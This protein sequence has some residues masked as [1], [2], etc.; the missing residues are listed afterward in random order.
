MA[1]RSTSTR[2]STAPPPAPP[3]KHRPGRA[4]RGC[5]ATLDRAT[6]DVYEGRGLEWAARRRPVRRADARA[7]ATAVTEGQL[8]IDVGCGAGRY[9]GDLGRPVIGVDAARRML[10][11]CRRVVP[12]AL[13]VQ[14][15]IEALPFGA[16]S[17][18]G[19]WANMS[20]LHV[21]R[22][23]LPLALADLH[24]CLLPGAPV[25]VQVLHG[26]YEGN[27]LPQDDVGGRFFA[28]WEVDALR[29]VLTGAGF[30]VESCEVTDDVVRARVERL[31]T[32]PEFVGPDMSVL[33]VGL[34][35]S[36]YAADA[37][38]GFARPGN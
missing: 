12:D 4:R 35:P 3:S 34:N 2:S 31:R 37:G 26:D 18:G 8:R 27:A 17:F 16:Q 25:D 6:I 24:R 36:L 19:A 30:A 13:L 1:C 11:Q 33:M 14:G 23:R 5:D 9:T 21:P 15:D 38:V 22:A 28:A 7:W 10:D 32:L 29:D 20:Y